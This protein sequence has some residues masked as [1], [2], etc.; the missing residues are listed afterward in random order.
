MRDGSSHQWCS[1]Q[2]GSPGL[3]ISPPERL[4]YN[5]PFFTT[6]VIVYISSRFRSPWQIY[7]LIFYGLASDIC[8]VKEAFCVLFV[9]FAVDG[10]LGFFDGVCCGD[11]HIDRPPFDSSA[12]LFS[13]NLAPA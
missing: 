9:K 7:L 4:A 10:V 1:Y 2:I 8:S 5:P 3:P 11:E 12:L 6:A 13:T